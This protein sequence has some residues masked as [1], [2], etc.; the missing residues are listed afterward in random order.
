M[1]SENIGKD[2]FLINRVYL[3][4]SYSFLLV[5][6]GLLGDEIFEIAKT[7]FHRGNEAENPVF[8][9]NDRFIGGAKL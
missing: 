9:Q 1:G 8:R 2:D 6:G 5:L 4:H 3:C 7:D